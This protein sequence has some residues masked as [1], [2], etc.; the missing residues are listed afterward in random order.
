MILQAGNQLRQSHSPKLARCA[1]LLVSCR[2]EEIAN[3]KNAYPNKHKRWGKRDGMRF[4]ARTN[5]ADVL[6]AKHL[7]RRR[8]LLST[9]DFNFDCPRFNEVSS[10]LLPDFG[11]INKSVAYI[12]IV[13]GVGV[14]QAISSQGTAA[15]ESDG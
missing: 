8:Q 7:E 15:L 10:S 12:R 6:E 3:K 9:G 13:P 14:S 5:N 11:L 1:I 4:E 2:C